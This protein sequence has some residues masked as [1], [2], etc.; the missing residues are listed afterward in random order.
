VNVP[1]TPSPEDVDW[2]ALDGRSRE[3]LQVVGVRLAFDRGYH[4]IVDELNADPPELQHLVLPQP[5]TH[6]WVAKV[7]GELR[8]AIV[9]AASTMT[10]A[11]ASWSSAS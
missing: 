5:I 4:D 9:A 1:S 7:V 6:A 2:T 10:T 3:L 8:S 11:T